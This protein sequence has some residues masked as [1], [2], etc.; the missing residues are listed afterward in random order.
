ML[1]Q[2]MSTNTRSLSN[3]TVLEQPRA[4]NSWL[5]ENALTVKMSNKKA[6]EVVTAFFEQNIFVSNFLAKKHG[7]FNKLTLHVF[8]RN[9]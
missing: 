4:K 9:K 7:D 2:C 3:Q 8:N 1:I 5:R 6:L